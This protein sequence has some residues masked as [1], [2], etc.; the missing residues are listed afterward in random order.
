MVSRFP[1]SI[2]WDNFF[3]HETRGIVAPLVHAVIWGFGL[4]DG[5]SPALIKLL[6]TSQPKSIAGAAARLLRQVGVDGASVVTHLGKDG[7]QWII[8][9]FSIGYRLRFSF[10]TTGPGSCTLTIRMATL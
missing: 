4:L 9:S 5:L 2:P 3:V 8:T 1:A 10:S 7:D 6:S